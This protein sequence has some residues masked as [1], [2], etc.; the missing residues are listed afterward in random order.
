M[1]KT[2]NILKQKAFQTKHSEPAQKQTNEQT[3]KNVHPLD[4]GMAEKASPHSEDFHVHD[5]AGSAS[6]MD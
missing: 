3:N 6:T 4:V 1:K 2:R 5:E